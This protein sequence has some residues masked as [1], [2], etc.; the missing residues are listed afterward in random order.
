MAVLWDRCL[1]QGIIYIWCIDRNVYAL[2]W[3][4]VLVFTHPTTEVAKDCRK[5]TS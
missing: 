3:L 1:E 2:Q 5:I 4:L